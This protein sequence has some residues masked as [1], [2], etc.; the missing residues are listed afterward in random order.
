LIHK[1]AH[2][3]FIADVS[4]YKDGLCSEPL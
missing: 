1:V 4:P 3:I 2:V